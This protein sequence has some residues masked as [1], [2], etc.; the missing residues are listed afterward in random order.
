V[1]L[2]VPLL[3]LLSDRLQATLASDQAAGRLSLTFPLDL[4]P[5]LD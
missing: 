3:Q 5:R 1:N 4:D 2:D